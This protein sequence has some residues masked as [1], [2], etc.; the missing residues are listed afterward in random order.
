MEQRL[1][2]DPKGSGLHR[3]REQENVVG[4]LHRDPRAPAC[5][6]GQGGGPLTQ[7]GHQAVQVEGRRSQGVD[8]A[9]YL[10]DRAPR[11]GA[12]TADS[13]LHRGRD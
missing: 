6:E 13:F 4:S 3:S 2:R 11:L 8:D 5:R 12:Q 10:L 1:V 7:G 9:P